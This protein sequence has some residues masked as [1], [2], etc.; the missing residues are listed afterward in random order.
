MEDKIIVGTL[1]TLR[2]ANCWPYNGRCLATL[3]WKYNRNW[4]L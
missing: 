1:H 2:F 4:R 3:H